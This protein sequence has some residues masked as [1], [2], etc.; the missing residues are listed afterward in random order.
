M[1]EDD[2]RAW[3]GMVVKRWG[4][5][6]SVALYATDIDILAMIEYADNSAGNSSPA[7]L[8]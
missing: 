4:N 6:D 2:S 3:A 5:E 7:G 1:L 8:V